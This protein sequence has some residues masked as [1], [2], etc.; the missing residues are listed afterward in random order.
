MILVA[1]DFK[2][3]ETVTP[4]EGGVQYRFKFTNSQRRISKK[5]AGYSQL[6]LEARDVLFAGALEGCKG[7]GAL[8]KP[9]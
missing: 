9:I 4:I 6:D 5:G 1:T 3:A 8:R 7:S 2:C